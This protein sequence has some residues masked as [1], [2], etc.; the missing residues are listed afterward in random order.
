[1]RKRIMGFDEDNTLT[2]AN[3]TQVHAL[4]QIRLD[5]HIANS[6]VK[7]LFTSTF[8]VVSGLQYD[9]IIGVHE[10]VKRN[11]ISFNW[12]GSPVTP[13][14]LEHLG[15]MWL[16]T[17]KSMIPLP[18][19]YST[20]MVAKTSVRGESSH[21]EIKKRVS[22]QERESTRART[23]GSAF[24]CY[25]RS[26]SQNRQQGQ[27]SSDSTNSSTEYANSDSPVIV[28]RLRTASVP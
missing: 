8:F 19:V 23:H 5:W 7:E 15:I 9:I 18:L 2:L 11:M 17:S 4:G 12:G 1:M 3:G 16:N 10:A 28:E 21:G 22:I 6:E 25:N 26:Q 24:S 27:G 13:K 20:R 14:H